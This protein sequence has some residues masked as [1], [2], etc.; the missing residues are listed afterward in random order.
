M[1]IGNEN[2]LNM[3]AKQ[4]SRDKPKI[5][6]VL[7]DG[8]QSHNSFILPTPVRLSMNYILLTTE[9]KGAKLDFENFT[10]TN[11]R[12]NENTQITT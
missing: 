10:I 6:W 2:L 5:V 1:K 4:L 8:L 7:V 11:M 9:R 12:E 3:D